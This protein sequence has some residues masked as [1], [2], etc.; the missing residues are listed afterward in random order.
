MFDSKKYRGRDLAYVAVALVIGG[1]GYLAFRAMYFAG[2]TMPFAQEMVLVFLGA[3]ATI[4]LTAALLNRQT[5]LELRKEGR[6]IVLQQKYDIYIAC[7][8][9]VAQI[10]E[11]ERYDPAL[12]DQLRVL[13]H[14]LAVIGS[15]EAV[16]AFAVVLDRLLSGLRDG[17]LSGV[18]GEQVMA[19]LADMTA[20][21]RKDML[22]EIGMDDDATTLV[23]IRGNSERMEQLDD[24]AE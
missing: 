11:A 8:E 15:I 24:Y 4:Y 17:R 9:K 21:M 19:A 5:E 2:A 16:E 7:I 1:L 13:N 20:A 14:K 3:V 6:V 22:E 23:T 18:D 10:V 12:I